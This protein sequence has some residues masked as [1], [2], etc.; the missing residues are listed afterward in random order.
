MISMNLVY[1]QYFKKP[2]PE[3][4]NLQAL[5]NEWEQSEDYEMYIF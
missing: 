2:L 4:F 1:M 3:I 5:G